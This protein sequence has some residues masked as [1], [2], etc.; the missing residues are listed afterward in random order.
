MVATTT[1]A[2]DLIIGALRNINALESAEVP[3]ASD[4]N[5]ALQVLNDMLE[6]WTIEKLLVF[7][8]T[9]NRF[10]FQ[11]GVYQYTIGNYEAGNFTGTLTSG[12]NIISG[13]TIPTNIIVGSMITDVQ[14][15]IPTKTPTKV[16]AIGTNTLTLS[17][18]ALFTVAT[19][20]NFTYTIPGAI[21]YDSTTGN[22]IPLPVRITNAFTRITVGNGDPM[23]QGLDYQIRIIPRDKYTAL[24]LKGIA[25]PWPTD[26]YYDRTYPLGNIYF[27]PNPSMAG[28]LH[29]WTDTILSDLED[30]NAPIDL[31]QGYARAIKTNLAIELAA[32]YGKAIPPS[33]A[34]RAKEAKALIKSLNAIPEIQAFFDQ[35]ILK[36]RRADAGFILHGGF[37]T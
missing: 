13:V 30:I 37:Y 6:S 18:N 22:P 12:S 23:I 21:G 27:Y 29:Y 15:A 32:E 10:V 4:S 9:E 16:T 3:N 28:E 14:A 26:L 1:S 25:G 5:D 17:A 8:S 33:L 19:P 31:P 35:H 34:M 11:P 36:S 24:G 20:E 7:S 2:L